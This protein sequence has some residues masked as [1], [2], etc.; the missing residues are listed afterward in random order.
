MGSN[1]GDDNIRSLFFAETT[2]L[3][4]DCYV[5]VKTGTAI[6][7]RDHKTGTAGNDISD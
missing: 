7:L 3:K 5:T 4:R 1:L 2:S 6:E